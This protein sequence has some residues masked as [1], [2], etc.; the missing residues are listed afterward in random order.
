MALIPEVNNIVIAGTTWGSYYGINKVVPLIM[1][2]DQDLNQK[3]TK[4]WS[5]T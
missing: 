4:I 2:V 5:F 1:I 3:V